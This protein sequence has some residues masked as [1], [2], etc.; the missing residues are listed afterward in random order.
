MPLILKY[1]DL[2]FKEGDKLFN[3]EI[4]VLEI[5]PDT[6]TCSNND[7]LCCV[8]SRQTLN[9]ISDEMDLLLIKHRI[10]P[11]TC[12]FILDES[13]NRL[14][15]DSINGK[16][17]TSLASFKGIINRFSNGC[18]QGLVKIRLRRKFASF[19]LVEDSYLVKSPT[20]ELSSLELVSLYGEESYGCYDKQTNELYFNPLRVGERVVPIHE[21]FYNK[22]FWEEKTS[23]IIL[24]EPTKEELEKFNKNL[25]I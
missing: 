25:G 5:G 20:I 23:I 14:S 21:N 19:K 7:G 18:D 8:Y 17:L 11:S 2:G 22:A 4:T 1:Q 12:Q 10:K 24:E 3:G 16:I 9:C 6:F 13:P 15:D